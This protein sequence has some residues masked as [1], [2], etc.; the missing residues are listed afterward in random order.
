MDDFPRML[1]RA[2]GGDVQTDSGWCA[3]TIVQDAAAMDAALSDGWAE[4]SEAAAAN[5]RDAQ[6]PKA[7]TSA[8]DA[9]PTRAELER[10]AAELGI[11]VDGRWSDK[12]MGE[13]IS[14]ALAA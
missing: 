3:Y 5:L 12:R 2:P 11:R 8:D 7:D 4:T 9:P 6:A 1:Y 10:K 14:K 13:E